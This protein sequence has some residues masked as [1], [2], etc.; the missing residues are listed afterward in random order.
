[1]KV[2]EIK[3]MSPEEMAAKVN[4]LKEESLNLRFQNSFGQLD[5]TSMLKK[6]R[7]DIARLKTILRDS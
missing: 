7:K 5:N 2:K 4:D 6:V 1:M 3:E